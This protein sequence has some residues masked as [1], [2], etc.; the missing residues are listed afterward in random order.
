MRC[1]RLGP[2]AAAE[3]LLIRIRQSSCAAAGELCCC[4]LQQRLLLA[5][6]GSQARFVS[7]TVQ[8]ASLTQ[9]KSW[10]FAGTAPAEASLIQDVV[11]G[12]TRPDI[13]PDVAIVS[14]MDARGTLTELKVGH[15]RGASTYCGVRSPC[16]ACHLPAGLGSHCLQQPRAF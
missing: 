8:C 15:Q 10:P 12:Y 6:Y 5:V 9:Q 4:R 16:T 3:Q 14:L 11:R 7:I 13:A 2:S 1:R